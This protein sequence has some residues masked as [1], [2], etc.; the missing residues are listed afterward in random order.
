MNSPNKL[1]RAILDLI[2]ERRGGID[3]NRNIRLS[4]KFWDK[5]KGE[6]EMMGHTFHEKPT[7][8]NLNEKGEKEYCIS[9]NSIKFNG[10]TIVSQAD[11]NDADL[12]EIIIKKYLS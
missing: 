10:G 5:F 3:E 6:L 9:K 1:I 4:E 8:S 11:Y 2:E 12:E 7:I